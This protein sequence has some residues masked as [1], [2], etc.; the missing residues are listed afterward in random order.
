MTKTNAMT[1]LLGL[2]CVAGCQELKMPRR[3]SLA[4]ENPLWSGYLADPFVLKVGDEYY[5]Y[6]TGRAPDGRQ[7][8]VLRSRDFAHWEFVGGALAPLTSPALKDYWAPEVAERDG[9]FYLYYA[10]DMKM[11]VAV[12]DRP[13]GPFRDTGRLMFP[14]LPFSIDGHPFHDPVS[15][16]WYFFFAQDFFDARPGTAPAVVQ[17]SDDMIKPVG[18]VTTVLR[19]FADWQIYERNRSL[20]GRVWEAWHTIEGPAVVYRDGRYYCFYSGGNWQTPGYGVGCAVADDVLGPYVDTNSREA[21]G[22]LKSIPGKL[23]GPGHCSVILGPDG[24]TYFIVY[25]SWNDSRT[26]RQ[27]CMDPLVWTEQGPK[28]YQPSRGRKQIRLPL[29]EER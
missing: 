9:R 16:Q 13:T 2:I 10:G 3:I 29:R 6:G 28:A 22:V 7:F 17:L 24:Q 8:P 15:G 1:V 25:H 27:I 14:N 26:A 20:Y 19:A 5:A 23:I 18:P 11:R 21:A 4:Y 12:A